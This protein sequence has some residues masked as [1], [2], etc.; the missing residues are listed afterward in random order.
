MRS[1]IQLKYDTRSSQCVCIKKRPPPP[2]PE[3]RF[4][5]NSNSTIYINLIKIRYPHLLL[6]FYW[7]FTSRRVGDLKPFL[8]IYIYIY[9]YCIR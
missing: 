9:Y 6:I 2:K 8:C 1:T 7:L 5:T 4:N 3:S